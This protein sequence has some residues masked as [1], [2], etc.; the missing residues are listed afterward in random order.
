MDAVA[1]GRTVLSA[2]VAGQGSVKALDYAVA[3]LQPHHFTDPVQ[4]ILFQLLVRYADQAGGIMTREALGDLLRDKK[5]GT[6]LMYGEAYDALAAAMPELHA[7]RHSVIQLRDL[8]A[9]RA[10]GEALATGKLILQ[11]AVRL[12]DGQEVHGHADARAYV[13]AAFAEAEQFGSEADTPEGNVITEG[14]EVMA[15]Y[16]RAKALHL[17]G[18]PIGVQF[19]IP[20]LD[21]ALGGG[22]GKG[23]ALVVA[24]T[25]AGKSSLVAQA[26]W[27]NAVEEGRNVLVFTTEQHRDEVRV[28][29]VSRHSCLPKFG[30]PRGLD[31]AR[32]RAG[33]LS[34]D[35]EKVLDW[36]LSDLKG[37]G[38][39]EL[40]VVQM[41]ERCTVSVMTGRA[42][43]IARRIMPDLVVADYL[44]LFD[45]ERRTRDSKL[46]EDQGGIVKSS[47]RWAQTCFHG[48]GVPL[49]SPWQTNR[50]GMN[51]LRTGGGFSLD[52]HM[53]QSSE[54]AKT[55]G[56]VLALAVREEDT[57]RGR[58][59]PLLLSVEKNRDG[60][61]GGRFNI[62]ADYATSCFSDREAEQNQD[63]L[64]LDR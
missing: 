23:L 29:L 13:M 47:H 42:E 55:A 35:E 22:I 52:Q 60:A 26:A 7:F 45:P 44:Q 20:S 31:S 16:A 32:I 5:P 33:K 3:R 17:A 43:A 64:E 40:Q 18:K 30:L 14:G 58:A 48:R 28:K 15:A 2:I 63:F 59:V 12:D 38:Y 37:G 6:E 34:D 49:V 11:Q 51:A 46:H 50:D 25:S 54:A 8:A 1:H 19:G 36:V 57:S 41:P 10:T 21:K 61:R 62:T 9:E 53:A 56:V 39:G 4:Q 24:G 27:H